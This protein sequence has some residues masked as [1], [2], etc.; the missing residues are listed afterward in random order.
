MFKNRFFNFFGAAGEGGEGGGGPAAVQPADARTFLAD[1]VSNPQDLAGMQDAAVIQLHGK[2]TGAL[3]KHGKANPQA[4]ASGK[5]YDTFKDA[6]TKTWLTNYKDAYPDP[7]SLAVKAYNLEKFIGAEKSGRGVVLPKPDAP[8]EEWAAF[9]KKY[10]G[11]PATPDGYKVAPELAADP[12]VKE[13]RAEAHKL[14]VPAQHFENLLTWYVGKMKTIGD[15]Q[16]G[17]FS[18]QSEKEWGELK[19]EWQGIEFDKNVELGRRAAKSFIPH[20]TPEQL[21]ESMNKIEGAL[22]TKATMKLWASIG[23]GMGEHE[24]VGG[25]GGGA[26]GGGMTPEGARIRISELKADKEWAASYAKG[27]ADKKAEWDR[28]HVIAYPTP[29]KPA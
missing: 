4:P 5:W 2:V 28:L 3:A 9:H 20:E 1:F 11:V 19:V 29:K 18:V 26:M 8:A 17:D 15:A 13:F 24:M 16:I 7:E 25:E 12:V 27:D 10:S 14:G 22:G 6:D 21:A 23:K